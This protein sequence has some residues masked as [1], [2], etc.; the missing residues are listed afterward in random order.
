MSSAQAVQELPTESVFV[1]PDRHD[2][3]ALTALLERMD[4]SKDALGIESYGISDTSLEE[5][6]LIPCQLPCYLRPTS[7][8]TEIRK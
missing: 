6:S 7:Q 1:L 4:E 5:V 2:V 3:K 8:V